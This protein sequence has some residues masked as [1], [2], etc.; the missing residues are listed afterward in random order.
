MAQSLYIT[1][2]GYRIVQIKNGLSPEIFAIVFEIFARET[3]S[4]YN[5]KW[6]SGFSIPSI[7]TMH[8]GKR[9]ISF[10]RPKTYTIF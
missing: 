3:E 7:S 8:H 1:G 10:L 4:D 2:F 6:C 9:S 5:L